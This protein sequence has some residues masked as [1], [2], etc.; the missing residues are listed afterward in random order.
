MYFEDRVLSKQ[1]W[2]TLFLACSKDYS[3]CSRRLQR[4]RVASDG[5]TGNQEKFPVKKT[6]TIS[7]DVD[8]IWNEHFKLEV[9]DLATQKLTV[10]V[11]DDEGLQPSQLIGSAQIDLK[12][13]KA[14]ALEDIWVPCLSQEERSIWSLSTIL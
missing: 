10:E 11:L 4:F 2:R 1:L 13:L 6:K 5:G 3:H 12:N 9:E 14:E 7:N 8:P